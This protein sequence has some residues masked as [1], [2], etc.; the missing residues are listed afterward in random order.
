MSSEQDAELDSLLPGESRTSLLAED[1]QHWIA[2]YGEFTRFKADLLKAIER[3]RAE[4]T[5]EVS[6]ALS[7]SV[8][9]QL[10]TQYERLQR[11]LAFW[12]QRLAELKGLG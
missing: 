2:V 6:S 12:Q 1:A 7:V 5:D 10:T 3:E 4:L 9:A 8:L 11:R